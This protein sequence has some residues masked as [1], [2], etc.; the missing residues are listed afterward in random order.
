LRVEVSEFPSH[1]AK[2]ARLRIPPQTY[3]VFEH[4]EPISAIGGTW[5]AI[6]N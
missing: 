1:P 3:A 5:K 2:F 6:W 4:R